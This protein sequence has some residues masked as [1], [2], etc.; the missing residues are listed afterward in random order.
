MSAPEK[1]M[2]QYYIVYWWLQES[3]TSVRIPVSSWIQNTE[4]R[5]SFS[6]YVNF[7]LPYTYQQVRRHAPPQRMREF[8]IQRSIPTRRTVRYGTVRY[9]TYSGRTIPGTEPRPVVQVRSN[10]AYSR[11]VVV[12]EYGNVIL[13]T[14]VLMFFNP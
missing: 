13:D 7:R 5:R 10:G 9:G 6:F 14:G 11:P 8:D 4:F 2:E 1:C 12:C 3:R